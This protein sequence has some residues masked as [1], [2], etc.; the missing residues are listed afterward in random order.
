MPER[1][2]L[3]FD[4]LSRCQAEIERGAR[5]S[6]L[7]VRSASLR[8]GSQWT[9]RE[10]QP[11]LAISGWSSRALRSA[12]RSTEPGATISRAAWANNSRIFEVRD[13]GHL[14]LAQVVGAGAGART[15][16]PGR[17]A[18]HAFRLWIGAEPCKWNDRW[19]RRRVRPS[20]G[21]GQHPDRGA[22]GRE[23]LP[24][25]RPRWGRILL[26]PW[27]RHRCQG[28]SPAAARRSSRRAL[29]FQ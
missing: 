20:G 26:P 28:G 13:G 7:R 8:K 5:S 16:A 10:Q 1:L 23:R 2:L 24:G 15:I 17:P 18:T 19:R 29:P 4:D 14:L 9:R 6:T 22:H 11:T 25:A 3:D 12:S 27:W 21:R